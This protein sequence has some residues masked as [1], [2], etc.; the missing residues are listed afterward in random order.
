[1]LVKLCNLYNKMAVILNN[2]GKFSDKIVFNGEYIEK[3]IPISLKSAVTEKEIYI[4]NLLSSG[5]NFP[6]ITKL[7]YVDNLSMDSH[8]IL[9]ISPN[10]EMDLFDA[11]I[12]NYTID[13]DNLKLCIILALKYVHLHNIIH[14]DVK[15]ENI[16]IKNNKFILCD[17]GLSQ[18][19]SGDIDIHHIIS[20]GTPG[21]IHPNY[22]KT[23]LVSKKL[24]I[25]YD[26]FS[27]LI[28]IITCVETNENI[29][30][31]QNFCSKHHTGRINDLLASKMTIVLTSWIIRS[32]VIPS[33]ISNLVKSGDYLALE[34]RH[35]IKKIKYSAK[36]QKI[37]KT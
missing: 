8:T 28:T 11:C 3:H 5:K 15:P 36:R 35:F 32:K 22:I 26:L 21:Y 24:G 20:R 33:W 14:L 7:L 25:T 29:N 17:F 37:I 31:W 2:G 23:G 13:I 12:N 10:A 34:Y 27:L 16:L 18:N 19:V 6:L 4:M 1:L 9:Y 30:D